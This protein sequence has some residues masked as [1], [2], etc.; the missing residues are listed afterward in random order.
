MFVFEALGPA[1]HEPYA[2]GWVIPTAV[3]SFGREATIGTRS[4]PL[5]FTA[6]APWIPVNKHL[7]QYI[8]H[9][10]LLRACTDGA[11]YDA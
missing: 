10:C 4:R 8:S 5:A 7:L 9:S 3:G 11:L 1:S 6:A 2:F